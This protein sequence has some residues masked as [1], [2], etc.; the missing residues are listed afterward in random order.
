MTPAFMP[1]P[2]ATL[3]TKQ[4]QDMHNNTITRCHKSSTARLAASLAAG[5]LL[6]GSC[7]TKNAV[8]PQQP[9]ETT[10]QPATVQ[11][12]EI[13]ADATANKEFV[14][15]KDA[16]DVLL[17]RT[18]LKALAAKYGYKT[19]SGYAVYRLDSYDTM[20]YKNCLPAKKVGTG[21]YADTPQ[22]QRKGTSS[23]VAMAGDVTIG[24]FNNKAY[25]NLVSQV[26]N[27]GF[28]LLEQGYEDHYSNGLIDIFC[29]ASRRTVR[30]SKTAA[31]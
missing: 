12:A 3:P 11:P 1:R 30:L 5:I 13:Q 31:Q 28:N 9:A 20:L 4:H 22:P 21:V 2:G 14:S 6:L 7:A 23:Y 18:E 8:A 27:A 26:K 17:G 10:Q 19:I 24:V 15:I 16:S 25:D 29:Y